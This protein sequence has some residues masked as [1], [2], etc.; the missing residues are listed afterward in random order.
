MT[1]RPLAGRR[2]VVTR[3]E[4]GPLADLLAERGAVMVHVPLIERVDAADGG[5]ELRAQLDRLDEF[6]WLVVTSP[7]GAT[8]VADAARRHPAVRLA[9]VGRSTAQE[10]SAVTGREV[11]LVP[12]DQHGGAL[13]AAL[14]G[15][16]PA[17]LLLA[18]ADRA[19]STLPDAL[20]AAGH[21]VTVVTAYR[22]I[23]VDGPAH[24]PAP[25]ADALLLASGSAAEAWVARFGQARP[26][27]VVAI[28][29]STAAVATRCGLKVDGVAAD[30]SLTGLVTALERCVGG[31]GEP[32]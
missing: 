30:H 29:P 32:G 13:A 16:P 1:G 31:P 15:L 6:D 14:A 20:R 2:V 3:E 24:G 22:T 12:D 4:P 11:D 18:V 10:L 8:R 9:A 19:P 17:R 21:D 23:A 7:A 26:G 5:A 25:A 27:V 28:G